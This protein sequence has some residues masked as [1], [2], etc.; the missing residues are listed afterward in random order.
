MALSRR[1]MSRGSANIWPGFV[2]AMTALILV[3]FF[4]L[5][6]FMIVQF[7]LRETIDGQETELDALSSEISGLAAALGLQEARN[8][9]LDAE[10]G[11]LDSRLAAAAAAAAANLSARR[12]SL[13]CANSFLES[14]AVTGGASASA[15]T[16]ATEPAVPSA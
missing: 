10:I 8:R 14:F 11:A 13:T 3:L 6:I 7:T 5:S 9:A 2:D 12:T 15:A 16:A 1:G 4:V